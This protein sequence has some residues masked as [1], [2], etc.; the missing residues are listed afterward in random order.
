MIRPATKIT[1]EVLGLLLGALAI[2]L[3]VLVWRLQSGPLS[4]SFLTSMLEDVA[5]DELETTR[6]SIGDAAV[7][8]ASERRALT[9]RFADVRL[10]DAAGGESIFVPAMDIGLS[11][12]ALARGVLAPTSVELIG[13]SATM[14]RQPGTGVHLGLAVPPAPET[15]TGTAAGET[16]DIVAPLLEALTTGTSEDETLAY[17][18]RFG[19]RDAVMTFVDTVND[20]TWQAP[21]TDIIAVRDG[22]GLAGRLDA[23]IAVG[24]T[25]AK[26][27]LRG[28]LPRRE[29]R[30]R[31]D[32]EVTDLVPAEL[33]RMSAVFADYA[34]FEFPVSVSGT[35]DVE[36]DG[37]MIAASL[38]LEAGEGQIVSPVIGPEPVQVDRASANFELDAV[39][40]RLT[41]ASLIYEAGSNRGQATGTIDYQFGNGLNPALAEIDLAVSDA[42]LDFPGFLDGPV[43]V[44]AIVAKGSVDL[45]YFAAD[46]EELTLSASGG[47]ISV[48]GTVAGGEGSPAL[49]LTGT[50]ESVTIESLP[51]LWPVPLAPGA[52]RW[53][54]ENMSGG[55]I[56]TGRLDIDIDAGVIA[57]ADNGAAI[58]DDDLRFDF[59]A[60][61]LTISYID[62]MPPMLGVTARAELRG[63]RFD[64]WVDSARV[65]VGEGPPLQLTG[66]HFAVPA[67]NEKGTTG[68]IAFTLDGETARI[69]ALI[70][71]EPLGFI[72]SFGLDPW[73][74]GGAGSVSA[75]LSLP[76]VRDV[77]LEQIDFK[78][79]AR[80]TDLALANVIPDISIDGGGL[81]FDVAPVGLTARG[82]ISLNGVP[83]DLVWTELFDAKDEPST[84]YDVTANLD[85][86]GRDALGLSLGGLV[87]GDVETR[88]VL[89]GSGDDMTGG[90][91]TAD[92]TGGILKQDDIGWWKR[93]GVPATAELDI[94]FEEDGGY[95]FSN[96]DVA[97]EGIRATGSLRLDGEGRILEADF[98]VMKLGPA[99]DFVFS[100][101][102][103]EDGVL[104][105]RAA[106]PR[107]DAGPILAGLLSGD[108]PIENA[109]A[110]EPESA[111]AESVPT[112]PVAPEEPTPEQMTPED[113]TPD[114]LAIQAAF[115][116][117]AANNGIVL[118][119]ARAD[120][121][122]LGDEVMALS[123][124]AVAL[125]G[126]TVQADIAPTEEGTRTLTVQSMD[127][128]MVA[129]AI[130]FTTS[131]RGGALA[132]EATID[133]KLPGAPMSGKVTVD[134]FRVVNAPILGSILTL[135]SLTGI[136]DTLQGDGIY[137][138]SL[139]MPF[140]TT[141]ERF[142]IESARTSGPALGL[143]MNGQIDYATDTVDL[144]GTLVPAYTINSIL[145]G[146]PVLGP[147][148]VGREGEG[149]FAITYAVRGNS[150]APQTFV[151]PVSALAPGFLRRLFEFG[152]S[153]PPEQP[154]AAPAPSAAPPGASQ[155][156]G[157]ATASAAP[158]ADRTEP[159]NAPPTDTEAGSAP[160]STD[161][162]PAPLREPILEPGD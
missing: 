84:T 102:R 48:A 56:T 37:R 70:D 63:N 76:L 47:R 57:A 113:E 149:I 19:V 45:D 49:K 122:L 124:S 81:D 60:E 39:Q 18:T 12:P 40:Q 104:R 157:G 154:V 35:L 100:A 112:E 23:D 7:L 6:M 68:T 41:L 36:T 121:E 90:H 161:E 27:R 98:P 94:A 135:G 74:V 95:R 141:E 96:I 66:G 20:V 9:F 153:M 139:D 42:T 119:G 89:T 72:S 129:N 142:H 21:R 52:R 1:L 131:L 79:R 151:N 14:A 55:T 117:I 43:P 86:D 87:A 92:I 15:E 24:E 162:E 61:D 78:A 137:F 22:R 62:T 25:T 130:D 127:A 106:G 126:V 107:F 53:V 33:A 80:T 4:I 44:E 123:A 88:A 75:D 146:V 38:A 31:I 103:A 110:A 69:L 133:D 82:R 10:E 108:S 51:G 73:T 144:S 143:T 134:K 159:A 152:S 71:H 111:T 83:T 32:A 59:A 155:A 11:V 158:P 145:G 85:D 58:P 140:R 29:T 2:L 54:M 120:L 160:G 93:A 26:L 64:A 99:N 91:I 150:D 114:R 3:A 118:H 116:E 8:W 136:R 148:I 17:L 97:G 13:I 46:V 109:M 77:E 34:A 101:A 128:G 115:D 147:L 5:N 30:A 16:P 67:L 132:V 138:V 28:R 105:M 65:E 125:N 156:S 50:V